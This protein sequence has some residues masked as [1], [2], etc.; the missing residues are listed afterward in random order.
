[1]SKLQMLRM[2]SLAGVCSL[3]LSAIANAQDT[4]GYDVSNNTATT[5]AAPTQDQSASLG[6]FT[7]G[8]DGVTENSAA[9]G[10]YNGMPDSGVGTV[11]SWDVAKRDAWDSGSTRY[12]NFTGYDVNFGNGGGFAPEGTIDLNIGDQGRWGAFATYDA[13]TY[14]ASNKFTTILDKSGDLDAG[15][16]GALTALGTS[17]PFIGLNYVSATPPTYYGTFRQR[18][19]PLFTVYAAGVGATPGYPLGPGLVYPANVTSNYDIFLG[20]LN[21]LT[22]K[23]G[24]RRDK[25]TVGGKYEIGDWTLGAVVSHEHKEGTLE[26]AMTTSGSNGGFIPFAMPV[27]YDTDAYTLT[28]AY[29]AELLQAHFSY[30]FSNFIDH[31]NGGIAFEGWNFTAVQTGA[32]PPYNYAG[33]E[34]SGNYSLPPSNQAHTFSGEL[35]YDITPTTRLNG[36]VVYSLQLQ[37]EPFVA[38]T[39][40]QF[41]LTNFASYFNSN[42]TSLDGL[43]NTWFANV[44]LN[45]RPIQNVKLKAAYTLDSRDP[46]TK[47]MAIYGDPTDNI[48]PTTVTISGVSTP[49]QRIAAPESWTKQTASISAEYDF[50]P[51]TRVTA[52][53]TFKDDDRTNAITHHA[54]ENAGSLKIFTSFIPDMTASL[55]YTY[56]D[57]TAS[58]PDFSMWTRQIMSDCISSSN[59]VF[60]QGTLGCQQVPFYEAARTQNAVDGMLT[61]TLNE[62][63]SWSLFGKYTDNQYHNPEAVYN[64]VVS[65]SV[66]INHDYSLQAGPDFNY[67]FDPDTE[68]HLF[69][70]FLRTDRSMRA[71]NNQNNPTIP[72][73]DYYSEK[74]TY[75][76]HTAGISGT[77]R[78][79]ERWKFGADYIF[80]YGDQ[81]FAQAGSWDTTE[82]GQ[83]FGGDPHLSTKSTDNQFKIHA[84]YDYS[85]DISL[86]FGYRFDSLDMTDWAL[87]G[88]S[89]GQVV[90][91][92]VPPKYNVSTI[93][94]AVTVKM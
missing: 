35:A 79:N 1:M 81:A 87:V 57:R 78:A 3:S 86:Y 43:V 54:Q 73:V 83:L 85:S 47:T 75:D 53:Y 13:M 15:Y 11:G 55:G 82:A 18:V 59:G 66:G 58:A 72:G 5:P 45:S 32:A 89:I 14:S 31:N 41:A 39:G 80:S 84:V 93:T 56:S 33:Y 28:A 49:W 52:G 68:L 76:I 20:S 19:Y 92:D 38:A 29:D 26:Q 6:E 69:Y 63:A 30:E 71:L 22:Y 50:D 90:T 23:I 37:N 25:G 7:F 21:E 12:Y 40:N 60:V 16:L 77:W 48:S 4:G 8:L 44:M 9:W 10:R 42:P 91:G 27:D 51:S 65:P 61:G 67:Q 74:T 88:K 36:T 17:G 24:T 2:V 62:K 34:M 46:Q 64:T 70:T 94:A